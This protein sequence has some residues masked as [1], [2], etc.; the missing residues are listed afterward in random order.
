MLFIVIGNF[1]IVCIIQ[2]I[3]LHMLYSWISGD[4]LWV[5]KTEKKKGWTTECIIVRIISIKNHTNCLMPMGPECVVNAI[6][7]LGHLVKDMGTY[8]S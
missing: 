6:K 3:H 5:Y 8:S 1:I 4:L 2:F 7:Y